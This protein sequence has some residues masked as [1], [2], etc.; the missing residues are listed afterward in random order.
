MTCDECGLPI[1]VCN[2]IALYRRVV[3]LV[4]KG[5]IELALEVAAYAQDEINDW[6]DE[7]RGGQK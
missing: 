7:R 2:A 5:Q 4:Q 1:S 6:E 3:H